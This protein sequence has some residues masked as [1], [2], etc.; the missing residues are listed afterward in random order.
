MGE[1][2]ASTTYGERMV[3]CYLLC[4]TRMLAQAGRL[5]WSPLAVL[6]SRD[7]GLGMREQGELLSAFPLG[8]LLTQI[9]GGM[10]ADRFGGKSVQTVSM[11]A[12]AAGSFLAPTLAASHGA[13]GLYWLYFAMG[14]FIGPQQPAY[15]A[16]V[17]VW[18]PA[19]E[20]GLVSGL[21]DVGTVAGELAGGAG[22]A[23][24][25]SL[26]GWST[27][28]LVIGAI[29]AAYTLLWMALA[30]SR[31]GGG[32][33]GSAPAAKAQANGAGQEGKQEPKG[34]EP[35]AQ[36]PSSLLL[37]LH[38]SVWAAI[39]QHM[40]FNG[41]KYFF[42][43]WAPTYYYQHFGMGPGS[44]AAYLSMVQA[45]GVVAPF[46]WRQVDRGVHKASR[47]LLFARR[48]FGGLGFGGGG[49]CVLALAW[50]HASGKALF[51]ERAPLATALLLCVN[52]TFVTAHAFGFKPNY[53]DL[54]KKHSGF[55]MGF[56]NMLATGMTYV[57]PLGAAYAMEATGNNWAALFVA[58]AALNVFG[59]VVALCGTSV[60]LLDGELQSGSGDIKKEQ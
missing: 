5:A 29:S 20:L 40:S 43:S 57:V 38:T 48:F 59:A 19:S 46:M 28:F 35:P 18:F 44:S 26:L 2:G 33:G 39:L 10:A 12:I 52:S 49:A 60:R 11:L 3:Q 55:L 47:S 54:T 8:Y 31:P 50:L 42:S 25:G 27:T 53:N 45:V 58:I 4:A 51:A 23:M 17:S 9:L 16:M 14:L 13:Q 1:P 36:Q 7:L 41:S 6:I 30:Q 34:D 22:A 15:S 21:A 56:G 37:L 32:A 24:L